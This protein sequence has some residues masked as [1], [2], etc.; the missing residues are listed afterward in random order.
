MTAEAKSDRAEVRKEKKMWD[1]M[2]DE[3]G[4]GTICVAQSAESDWQT[5]PAKGRDSMAYRVGHEYCRTP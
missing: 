4:T 1:D 3:C 2:G 5:A